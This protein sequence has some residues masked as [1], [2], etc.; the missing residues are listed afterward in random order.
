MQIAARTWCA[1]IADLIC[2]SARDVIATGQGTS[3]LD[4]ISHPI[5]TDHYSMRSVPIARGPQGWAPAKRWLCAGSY[6]II[7]T[8]ANRFG[9]RRVSATGSDILRGGVKSRP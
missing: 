2:L 3:A 9:Q 6:Y 7:V 8:G 1:V 5:W 4:P